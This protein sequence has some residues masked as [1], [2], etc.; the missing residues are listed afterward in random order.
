MDRYMLVDRAV[1]SSYQT[2][3]EIE[4]TI[5]RQID[6]WMDRWYTWSDVSNSELLY[7]MA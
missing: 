7:S 6:R 5:S 1:M 3:L 2:T 4:R